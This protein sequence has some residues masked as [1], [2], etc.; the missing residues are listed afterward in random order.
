MTWPILFQLLWWWSISAILLLFPLEYGYVPAL[1][2]DD[3]FHHLIL[4]CNRLVII[5]R[6]PPHVHVLTDVQPAYLG[7]LIM[8]ASGS[9]KRMLVLIGRLGVK[10]CCSFHSRRVMLMTISKEADDT[11]WDLVVVSRKSRGVSKDSSCGL[12]WIEAISNL[13]CVVLD[14]HVIWLLIMHLVVWVCPIHDL[15]YSSTL[16]GSG[17]YAGLRG[18]RPWCEERVLDLIWSRR[19]WWWAG[20]RRVL[21]VTRDEY[22]CC[23]MW[24][25]MLLLIVVEFLTCLEWAVWLDSLWLPIALLEAVFYADVTD[26]RPL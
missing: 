24:S 7:I 11:W 26:C 4:P 20:G 15:P 1:L 17:A 12:G 3:L 13:T 18:L 19:A 10:S 14:G 8:K 25:G 5:L 9:L 22:Y 23:C 16:L 6:G 2:V 21:P